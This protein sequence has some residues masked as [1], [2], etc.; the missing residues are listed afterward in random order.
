MKTVCYYAPLL[1]PPHPQEDFSL[2]SE[3]FT[4][5]ITA[6]G[7]TLKT[8]PDTDYPSHSGAGDVAKIFC[9]AVLAEAEAIYEQFSLHNL[10]DLFLAGSRKVA[11]YNKTHHRTKELLNY[12][13]IDFFAATTSFALIKNNK[14]YWWSLCDAGVALLNSRGD[15]TFHSPPCWPKENRRQYLDKE[16]A[17]LGL[18]V[19]Q[20]DILIRKKYR[21][22]LGP[23]GELIGYGVVTGEETAALYLRTGCLD[24]SRGDTALIFTDGFEEYVPLDQFRSLVIARTESTNTNLRN[25]SENLAIQNPTLYGH[26]RSLIAIQI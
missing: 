1:T 25:L 23:H 19:T 10:V 14:M 3:K 20:R 13:G 6:D 22:G 8:P 21:N 5:A 17:R 11:T 15:I 18:D 12:W 26:E 16:V 24:I 2:S 4:I 9:E 7:V